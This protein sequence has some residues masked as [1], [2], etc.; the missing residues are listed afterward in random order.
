MPDPLWLQV[1]K[2]VSKNLFRQRKDPK[3]K[4]GGGW[5]DRQARGRMLRQT[6]SNYYLSQKWTGGGGVS[7]YKLKLKA[8]RL[9]AQ[10]GLKNKKIK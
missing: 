2:Q 5:V 8:G 4:W 1:E 7:K 9:K 6:E 10:V 3:M